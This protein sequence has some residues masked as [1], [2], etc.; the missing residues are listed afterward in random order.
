MLGLYQNAT[1]E[2]CAEKYNDTYPLIRSYYHSVAAME[3]R[4]NG[5]T[6]WPFG[7]AK[8]RRKGPKGKRLTFSGIG[9]YLGNCLCFSDDF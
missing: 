3:C 2:K 5:G 7:S 9:L 6:G 8:N 4:I 1:I